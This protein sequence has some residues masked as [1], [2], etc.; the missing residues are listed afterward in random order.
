MISGYES[1]T[2]RY[3]MGTEMKLTVREFGGVVGFRGHQRAAIDTRDLPA[4]AAKEVEALARALLAG[5]RNDESS[6][7]SHGPIYDI[8]VELDGKTEVIPPPSPDTKAEFDTLRHRI[9]ELSIRQ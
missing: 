5:S 6:A 9:V 3:E 4:H 2:G 1:K 7:T 8:A